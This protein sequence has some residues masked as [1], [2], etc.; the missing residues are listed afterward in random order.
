MKKAFFTLSAVAVALN[1]ANAQVIV[2]STGDAD[3]T[4]LGDLSSGAVTNVSSNGSLLDSTSLH[5]VFQEQTGVNVSAAQ[6]LNLGELNTGDFVTSFFFHRDISPN[7]EAASTGSVTFSAP[8]LGVAFTN[9]FG[10]TPNFLT[11]TDTFGI[12]GVTYSPTIANDGSGEQPA[13]IIS[14]SGNTVTFTNLTGGGGFA[15]NFR[16]FVEATPIPEPSST[17]L[18]GLGALGL[19]GRRKR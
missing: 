5:T 18:L 9:G 1:L 2:S 8:V 11:Q 19:I 15:E 6:S 4:R 13:E 16:V 17:L 10:G 12:A 7:G 14:F 3:V